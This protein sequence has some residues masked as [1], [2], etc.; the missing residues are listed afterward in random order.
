MAAGAAVIVVAI[1]G[2]AGHKAMN[3]FG[4]LIS[5]G[6]GSWLLILKPMSKTNLS[7][8]WFEIILGIALIGLGIYGFM[9]SFIL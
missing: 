7:F 8:K 6:V 2:F 3:V 4:I 5:I 9:D 1:I